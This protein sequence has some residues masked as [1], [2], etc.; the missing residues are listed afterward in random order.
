MAAPKRKLMVPVLP[1]V[2]LAAVAAGPVLQ[3][4]GSNAAGT[5]ST[6]APQSQLKVS[7]SFT[8]LANG[9][10]MLLALTVNNTAAAAQ[11]ISV[12]VNVSGPS[13][14]GFL[15]V[16]ADS[17]QALLANWS[18][19]P[20]EVQRPSG[21]G[22]FPFTCTATIPANTSNTVMVSTGSNMATA[23]KG[24]AVT[25]SAQVT[26]DSPAGSPLPA[27]VSLTQNVG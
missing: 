12:T 7:E 1:A 25:V 19:T 22:P 17:T 26:A 2:G 5:V 27:V 10:P 15:N 13:L 4:L 23:S 14:A 3:G 18:C 24:T 11:T 20:N 9:K 6:A 21:A 16:N 8:Q